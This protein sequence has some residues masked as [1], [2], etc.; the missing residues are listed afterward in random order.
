VVTASKDKTARVWNASTGLPVT[1]PLEHNG[2]VAGA[3]FSPDGALVITASFDNTARVWD[4]A[5]GKP[6]SLP[7]VHSSPITAAVFSPDGTRVVTASFDKTARVWNL[8]IDRRS[9]D[10]WLLVAR[11]SLFAVVHGVLTTN[12]DPLTVCRPKL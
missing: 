10:D 12:P 4:A 5:T 3:A 8:S 9:L 6:V 2:P 1:P 7:L 11:C